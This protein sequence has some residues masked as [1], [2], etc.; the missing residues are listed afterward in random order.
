MTD[1]DNFF[2]RLPVSPYGLGDF[3]A[4][5]V[6]D[7]INRLRRVLTVIELWESISDAKLNNLAQRVSER[8]LQEMVAEYGYDYVNDEV[9][10]LHQTAKVMYANLAVTIAATAETLAGHFCRARQLSYEGN[11]GRPINRPNWGH[12]KAA[13][14]NALNIQFEN[15]NGFELNRKARVMGNCFKHNDGQANEEFTKLYGGQI[16]D[17]IEY[18]TEA[19]GKII[20]GTEAFLLELADKL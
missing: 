3:Y 5:I 19:W 6:P 7:E 16:G 17:D 12:K 18:V 15:I 8:E 9:F 10:I 4:L 1:I 14:E 13:L 2:A 20:D 11:S